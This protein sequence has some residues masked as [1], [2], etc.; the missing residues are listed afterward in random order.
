MATTILATKAKKNGTFVVTVDF[1]DED[2][3][4]L[5]P[6]TMTWTLTNPAGETVNSRLDVSIAAP[7]SSE[8]IVLQ[9]DDLAIPE[10]S[11]E[12][13][14]VLTLEGTYTSTYGADLPFK[15]QVYFYIEDLDAV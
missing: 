1:T 12:V 10:S 13:L 4:T 5:T 7:T 9:G 3:S 11:R 14:R 6:T 2:G 8:N 15:D